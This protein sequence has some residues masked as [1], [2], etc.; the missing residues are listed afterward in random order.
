[1]EYLYKKSK[2]SPMEGNM[3]KALQWFMWQDDKK[4]QE[5]HLWCRNPF[6]AKTEASARE[7]L[8]IIYE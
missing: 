4:Q 8:L 6:F 1:M 2:S 5:Q 7:I 3:L